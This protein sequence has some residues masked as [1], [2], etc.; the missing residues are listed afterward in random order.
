MKIPTAIDFVESIQR[1]V[2]DEKSESLIEEQ[3]KSLISEL[4]CNQIIEALEKQIPKKPTIGKY[5]DIKCPNGHNIPVP[6]KRGNMK[7]CPMCGQ[8]IDWS[9]AE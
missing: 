1:N 8:A 2:R 5:G 3:A 4:Y 7:W 9:E 6:C